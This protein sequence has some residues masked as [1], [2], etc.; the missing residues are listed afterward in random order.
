M[1]SLPM[2][3]LGWRISRDVVTVDLGVSMYI[4]MIWYGHERVEAE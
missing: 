3:F 1:K 2:R 4:L